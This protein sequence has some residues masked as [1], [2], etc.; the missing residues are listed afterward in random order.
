M[1]DPDIKRLD[2]DVFVRELKTVPWWPLLAFCAL[3][4]LLGPLVWWPLSLMGLAGG[5]AV[6]LAA[7]DQAAKKRFISRRFAYLWSD[8]QDRLRRLSDELEKA[9][10][11]GVPELTELPRTVG[12]VS[13]TLYSALRRADV[14]EKEI[15]LSEGF[16][17]HQPDLVPPPAS[18]PEAVKLWRAAAKTSE[19]YQ[20]IIRDI[21]GGIERTEAQAHLFVQT[22]DSLRAQVLAHRLAGRKPEAESVELVR[23]LVEARMQLDSIGKA[24][25]EL[26]ATPFPSQGLDFDPGAMAQRVDKEMAQD[27][28]EGERDRA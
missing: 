2:Q 9:R 28:E 23:S 3:L 24:L 20:R 19:E 26:E 22:L 21:R 16:R 13:E 7:Q 18:D 11:S 10:S 15:G 14:S 12:A 27:S 17:M 4:L 6:W 25:N 5:A 1:K 8:C